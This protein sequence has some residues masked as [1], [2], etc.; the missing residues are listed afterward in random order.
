MFGEK[1]KRMYPCNKPWRPIGLWDVEDP[2]FSIHSL[3]RWRWGCEPYMLAG[4]PLLPRWFLVF[5]SVRL[6][7]PPGPYSRWKYY[8]SIN[9]SISVALSPRANYT[10][11]ATATCPWNLVSTFVDRGVSRGQ[12]GGSPTVVNLS[13]LDRWKYYVNRKYSMALSAMEPAAW[14]RRYRLAFVQN[15]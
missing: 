2:T 10:D 15:T 7:K 5:I 6:W 4:R 9:Q 13:F 8:Q 11:W 3:H 14:K 12:R 1:I